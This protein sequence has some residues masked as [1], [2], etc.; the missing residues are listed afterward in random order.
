MPMRETS[1]G[2]EEARDLSRQVKVEA[3]PGLGIVHVPLHQSGRP[4]KR[5]AGSLPEVNYYVLS[6]LRIQPQNKANVDKT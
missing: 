6:G 5:G 2:Q 3:H 1:P 4:H